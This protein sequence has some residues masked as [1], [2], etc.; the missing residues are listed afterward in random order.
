MYWKEK[1]KIREVPIS[2]ALKDLE[3]EFAGQF[4]RIHRNALIAITQID[5][6]R[7]ENNGRSYVRLKECSQP[8]E[9]SRRHLKPLKQL[10]ND[11]RILVG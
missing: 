1:D 4:L 3:E 5:S 11:M 10:L 2:E 7:K 9:V 8:L 6:L